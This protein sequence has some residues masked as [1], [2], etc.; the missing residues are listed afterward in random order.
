MTWHR[1]RT[2][3][4]ERSCILHYLSEHVYGLQLVVVR[5]IPYLM[6]Y[7]KVVIAVT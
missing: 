5:Y 1:T 4:D 2:Y 7:G 6:V 3:L